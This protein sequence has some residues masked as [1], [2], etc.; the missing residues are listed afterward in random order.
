VYFGKIGKKG[1]G[2]LVDVVDDG[3]VGLGDRAEE[4]SGV[5]GRS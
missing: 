2:D 1:G 5:K 3:G 4:G